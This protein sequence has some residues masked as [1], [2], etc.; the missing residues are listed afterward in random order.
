RFGGY[1]GGETP[2]PIPNPEVKPSS[3]DGTVPVTGW[4]SRSPPRHPRRKGP[5]GGPSSFRG[6]VCQRSRAHGSVGEA[7]AMAGMDG[8]AVQEK[9]WQTSDL[10]VGPRKRGIE[11][12]HAARART[13]SGP[14]AS[15]EARAGPDPTGCALGAIRH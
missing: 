13:A 3:A 15:A 11:R 1:S 9:A 5:F 12:A 4:E 2:G 7:T 8:R 14:E 6:Y 10:I